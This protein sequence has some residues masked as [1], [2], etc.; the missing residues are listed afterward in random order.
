MKLIFVKWI[1][2]MSVDAWTPREDLKPELGE[3]HSVGIIVA[4]DS[5]TLTLALN[6]DITNDSF[7]CVMNIPKRC[8]FFRSSVKLS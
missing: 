2:A 1:D 4:E 3:I 8:I 6:F 5:K 7:S